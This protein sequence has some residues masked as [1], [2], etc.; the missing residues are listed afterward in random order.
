MHIFRW[1]FGWS[2]IAFNLW[3]K[4]DAHRVVKDYAWYWGDAFWLMVMQHDLVFDG[5]YEI[6]PHPMYSVGYAGYYGLSMG[7]F[8]NDS[9][10]QK[11]L[12]ATP[13]C[14][15]RSRL[16]RHNLRSCSGSRTL[17]STPSQGRKELITD[18]ERTYGGAKKPL[19][20]RV[21]LFFGE[22]RASDID[23]SVPLVAS[24]AFAGA[25]ETQ[26]PGI[27]EGKSLLAT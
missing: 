21:P 23:S 26:T 14:S 17:V 3:V 10:L 9:R 20:S 4:M 11:S 7:E 13:S 19:A 8:R 1:V 6:A 24:N 18:I 16:M 5:V 2:L 22:Q 25:D 12:E 15:P 27:T